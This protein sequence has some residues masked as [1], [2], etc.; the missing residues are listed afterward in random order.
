M[1]KTKLVGVMGT[2]KRRIGT[3]DKIYEGG[4]ALFARAVYNVHENAENPIAIILRSH[5]L[6]TNGLN[7]E[8]LA[9]GR[10]GAGYDNIPVEECT[11][12]G[13]IV[14]N[15]PGANANAV[16]ELTIAGLFEAA[17]RIIPASK[18]LADLPCDSHICKKAEEIKKSFSGCEIMGKTLGVVGL[19]NIGKLVAKA[20]MDLGMRVI[21][22]DLMS[23]SN[24]PA[25]IECVKSLDNLRECD[26][27]TFHVTL[28]KSTEGMINVALINKL[29]HGVRV[30]N[31]SRG[32]IVN[33]NDLRDA[34]LTKGTVGYYVADFTH[35]ELQG[36]PNVTTL[37][38]LGAS[39][40]EAEENCAMMACKQVRD[41]L[42]E[43]AIY[44]SVNF[45]NLSLEPSQYRRIFVTYKDESNMFSN[46]C[47]VFGKRHINLP[48]F[49]SKSGGGVYGAG[50]ID[51]DF[52]GDMSECVGDLSS[53]EGV[54]NLR[55]IK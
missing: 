43:G 8:L 41:F 26:F 29:K 21:G 48:N 20:A 1:E 10:A 28:N 3:Y 42:E 25:G 51:F 33:A 34:L 52:A 5:K 27:V 22:Y 11:K 16:K 47:G 46:I 53:I 39:T 19:G 40:A 24:L 45:Q 31:F 23:T 50:L 38:H 49:I 32:E 35:Q 15:T 17:R 12:R 13:I 55:F 7:Q 18:A 36:L 9:V 54:V 2:E 14:F 44:N 6:M 37:P 4:L 30:L